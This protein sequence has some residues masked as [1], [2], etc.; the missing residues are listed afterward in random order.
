MVAGVSFDL[1]I[2]K[3]SSPCNGLLSNVLKLDYLPVSAL[4]ESKQ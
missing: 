3:P 2:D 1:Y 4:G